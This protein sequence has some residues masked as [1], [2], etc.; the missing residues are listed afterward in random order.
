M[1]MTRDP[2]VPFGPHVLDFDV[3]AECRRLEQWLRDSIAKE[4]HRRG[5]VVAVSGGVDSS[6]C[7]A[8]SVRALG[9]A[10][11][12]A[13]AMPGAGS[14]ETSALLARKLCAELGV[15]LHTIDIAPALAALGGDRACDEAIARVFPD[16]PAG[17]RHKIVVAEGLLERE[18]ANLFDLVAE[19]PDRTLRRARLPLDAYLQ[20]VAA[21]NRNQRVRKLLEYTEAEG[22]NYAVV[23][24]PNRLEYELGF[25][26][27]GGDGLADIEPIAHLYKT[28][29]WALAEHLGL[30][31]AIR[32]QTPSTETYTLPQTQEEFFFALPL[33]QLDLLLWAHCHGVPASAVAGAMGMADDQV[34][35]VYRDIA[36]KR[37]AAARLRRQPLVA[38]SSP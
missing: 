19:A 2:V 20:I 31:T 24:T 26:V 23:G 37:S 29:V 17:A 12:R 1:T 11:V 8:L 4:L 18:R 30:S 13:L 16:L 34:E 22:H 33:R 15:E 21:T 38:E 7:L 10:R 3:A 5:A 27:R 25:F 9:A 36:W 35:R 14:T 6:V 32:E 28:Q